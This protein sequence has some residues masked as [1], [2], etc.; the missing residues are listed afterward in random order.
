M[1]LYYNI[2][3]NVLQYSKNKSES[4]YN[5]EEY[6]IYVNRNYCFKLAFDEKVR[7]LKYFGDITND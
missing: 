3:E 6:G 4:K 1:L 2:T 5:E 7:D